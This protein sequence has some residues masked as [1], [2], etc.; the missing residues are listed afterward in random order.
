M[1]NRSCRG[2]GF[3][4]DSLPG[5]ATLRESPAA[6]DVASGGGNARASLV[7]RTQDSPTRG[8][9]ARAGIT[10]GQIVKEGVRDLKDQE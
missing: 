1:R 8:R 6:T 3:L 2:A 4:L 7:R 5:E 9:K 10:N